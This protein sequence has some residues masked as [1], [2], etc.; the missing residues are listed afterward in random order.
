MTLDHSHELYF[1]RLID[2]YLLETGHA[3]GGPPGGSW[4][5]P[6]S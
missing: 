6:E 2:R 1:K 5:V 4:L 3:P